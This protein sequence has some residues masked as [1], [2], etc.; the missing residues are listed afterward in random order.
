MLCFLLLARGLILSLWKPLPNQSK[1]KARR[2]QER[3]VQLSFRWKILKT[4]KPLR[5]NLSHFPPASFRHHVKY[6]D[7][8]EA[9][10]LSKVFDGFTTFANKKSNLS[11]L[12]T[13][14][15]S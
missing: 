6:G 10:P 8:G 12:L 15:P 13:L 3:A 1:A 2:K 7:H 4:T 5:E 9:Q 14:R 11:D